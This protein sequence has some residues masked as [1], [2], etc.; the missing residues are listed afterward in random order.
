M[1]PLEPREKDVIDKRYM[2]KI[3]DVVQ[4]VGFR[5][6]V[7]NQARK[8]AVKGWVNNRG[9]SLVI[10]VEGKAKE[11]REFIFSI[12]LNPPSL[13]KIE[14]IEIASVKYAGYDNFLIQK[15][16][17]MDEDLRFV[18]SD[19]GVC[20][21]CLRETIDPLSRW[22]KYS[23]T[24]CTECGPRYSIIK[25]LPY[26]RKNT[27][28]ES[29]EMCPSCR[30]DYEDPLN[31][32]FHA[33]P[34][35][36]PKCGPLLHLVNA[37]G[38]EVEYV[39]VFEKTIE[40]IEEGKILAIKGIGGFHLVCDAEKE[41]TV[42]LLRQRKNRPHKPLA[43]MARDL[44]CIQE[45]CKIS[46]MEKNL[47]E[48]KKKPIVLLE[49]NKGYRLPK[50]ISPD[51]KRIGMMLPY[52]SL[53]HLL[54]Q[55]NIRFLVM[56]SGNI[57]NA[58][59]QY[60]SAQALRELSGIVDYFLVHNREIHSPVDDSVTKVIRGREMM[61]RGAR[62]VSPYSIDMGIQ[63]EILALG[64]EQKSTFAI[65]QNGYGYMSQ[66]LG[67]IKEY[68]GNKRYQRMIE[69]IMILIKGNPQA[70]AYDMHP[71]FFVK[72]YADRYEGKK[73]LIQHH[74][75]HMVSCMVEHK[76]NGPIMAVIYDGTGFGLDGNNWGG[77]FLVGTKESFKR[78]G[79][80]QYVYIQGGDQSV[81]E[82][83]RTAVS[84]IEALGQDP[85]KYLKCIEETRLGTI[86]QAHRAKYN[87][88]KSSSVGRIFDCV[89]A[90]LGLCYESTYDGQ[91]AIILE[92]I[93]DTEIHEAYNFNVITAKDSLQVEYM[94]VIKGILD[95][96]DAKLPLSQIPSKFH[97]SICDITIQV[98]QMIR[99]QYELEE[100]ILSGGCFENNYL[101][102][103]IVERLESMG[104]KVFYNQ[105]IPIND[106]GISIGQLAIADQRIREE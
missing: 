39:D 61:I 21:K 90:L 97:N 51:T 89:S 57:S 17:A 35:C 7:Y 91:A 73:V 56:T 66:Y 10:D 59:I 3:M 58:P 65:S 48:S 11:I 38:Q 25:R 96:L 4:G 53:H 86:Q 31:R 74:H 28:M 87:C 63:K 98:V 106:S 46:S 60:E 67:D 6:F 18:P 33:Q 50:N 82:P 93:A 68:E 100:V 24:N 77:E 47:L 84:Y 44:A 27:T 1:R 99:K 32:R 22:F 85:R 83:W 23:F 94:E 64:A 78:V 29:F 101:L 30:G 54:F 95:D 102:V 92:N 81:K 75:A 49:K 19:V 71:N 20:K 14:R 69:H 12:I 62:G 16:D 76:L 43:I 88:Y 70:I 41:D 40:C 26:D 36:C 5:P 9:A 72:Q 13:A 104:M 37:Q 2:I 15:S 42:N 52:T 105:Q 8:Y 45:Q 80:F 103:T 55:K 79:H 34:T